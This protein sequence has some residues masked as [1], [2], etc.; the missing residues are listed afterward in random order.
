MGKPGDFVDN[1]IRESALR[2]VK[3]IAT[4][5]GI[6]SDLVKKREAEGRGWPL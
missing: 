4:E 3:K 1:A 2:T 5:S 6:I